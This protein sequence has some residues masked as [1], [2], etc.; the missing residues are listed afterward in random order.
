MELNEKSGMSTTYSI[1]NLNKLIF[2]NGDVVIETKTSSDSFA[3]SGT[4][5]IT[6]Q[7]IVTSLGGVLDA[8]ELISAYPNPCGNVLHLNDAF[9]NGI[10][11]IYD[12]DGSL[13]QSDKATLIINVA[14]LSNG[15][16]FLTLMGDNNTQTIKFIKQ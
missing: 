11:L 3:I 9:S 1:S 10:Y 14:G 15:V 8:A 4:R 13:V 2:Q 7:P 6:F 16:Y 5:S 12:S